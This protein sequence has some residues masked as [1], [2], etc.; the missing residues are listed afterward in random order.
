MYINERTIL[1]VVAFLCAT[2][3]AL[4]RIGSQVE[5]LPPLPNFTL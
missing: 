1:A 4:V 2:A 5:Q 3:L